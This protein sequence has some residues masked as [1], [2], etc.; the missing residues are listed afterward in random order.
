MPPIFMNTPFLTYDEYI[1]RLSWIEAVEELRKGHLLPKPHIGDIVLGPAGSSMLSRAAFID[2][3]GYAAKVETVFAGNGARGLPSVQGS[4]LL[5]DTETGSVRAIIESRL[6]TEYKTAG[7]SALGAKFLARPD[8]RHL[9]IV[10]AGAVARSLVQAY[11]AIFPNLEQISIWARRPEQ[12]KALVGSLGKSE[13]HLAAVVDLKTAVQGADIISSATMAGEP[14]LCGD[15]IQPG[16][17][18]DLIGGFTPNMREAD[19]DLIAKAQVFV[20]CRETTID[21]VG[22]LTQPIAAGI[23]TRDDVIGDLYDL[24]NSNLSPRTSEAS[25]TVFKNGGGAHLDLMIAAYIARISN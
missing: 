17:H 8:S 6:V 24:A 23:M 13:I 11:S 19:D 22:D 20:D 25:I 16:T 18:I 21:V 3:L 5:F 14:I 15:W 7:D 2:G 10:G 1:N 12:A 4:V 9:V